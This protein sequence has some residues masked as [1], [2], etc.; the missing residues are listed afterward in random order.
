MSFIDGAAAPD[1]ASGRA[2]P[3]QQPGGGGLLDSLR[4]Q[5]GGQDASV[6]GAGD[7]A[8]SLILLK[9]AIDL[10]QQALG[11]LDP[12][13]PQ[14][15]DSLNALRQLSRHVASGQAPAG[16]QQTQLMDIIRMIGRTGLL[17]KLRGNAGGP[18][19]PQQPSPSTPLPGA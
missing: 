2:T 18:G 6:P 10:I 15:R 7:Q 8:N 16:A 13:S 17:Q 14:H 11:G 3:P 1:D 9:N 5:Q 12:G 19:G 4:A